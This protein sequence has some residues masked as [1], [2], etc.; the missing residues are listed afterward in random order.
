[1]IRYI[2]ILIFLGV[3]LFLLCITIQF[4]RFV[5]GII[6][7]SQCCNCCLVS[8]KETFGGVIICFFCSP[9]ACCG[10]NVCSQRPNVCGICSLGIIELCFQ[11]WTRCWFHF[12]AITNQNKTATFFVQVI[13]RI[14]QRETVQSVI[15]IICIGQCGCIT[16]DK[17][18]TIHYIDR[19][20]VCIISRQSGHFTDKPTWV[21]QSSF[22][23]FTAQSVCIWI[24]AFGNVCTGNNNLGCII[25]SPSHRSCPDIIR[26]VIT[27]FKRYVV[28]YAIWI[29]KCEFRHIWGHSIINISINTRDAWT[30]WDIIIICKVRRCSRHNTSTRLYITCTC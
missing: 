10:S 29:N 11:F 27:I 17:G 22:N 21:I 9:I 26:F 15:Q 13:I 19:Y 23:I 28:G 25:P 16:I 6:I 1:M 20:G 14:S 12:F 8:I 7:V 18:F 4:D 24:V 5:L 3:L 2:L 30:V